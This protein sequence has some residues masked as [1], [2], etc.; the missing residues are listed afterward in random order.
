MPDTDLSPSSLYLSVFFYSSL[1]LQCS[2]IAY[3][4]YFVPGNDADITIAIAIGVGVP[5][6]VAL[7]ITV[8]VLIYCYKVKTR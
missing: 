8:L 7:I 3:C 6:I 2:N 5:C 4:A 1:F